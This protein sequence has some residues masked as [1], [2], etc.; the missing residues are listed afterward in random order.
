LIKDRISISF[1]YLI[2]R[3]SKHARLPAFLQKT[4][5]TQRLPEVCGREGHALAPGDAILVGYVLVAEAAVGDR[6]EAELGLGEV[7]GPF[8][9]REV[10]FVEGF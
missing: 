4:A 7:R 5:F 10:D 2:I 1:E 6:V 3:N 8:Y 9:G